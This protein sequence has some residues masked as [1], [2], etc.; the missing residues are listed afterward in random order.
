MPL[1]AAGCGH[2]RASDADREQA[3]EVLKVAFAQGR[4]AQD[5][6]EPRIGRAFAARTYAESGSGAGEKGSRPGSGPSAGEKGSRV[7]HIRDNFACPFCGRYRPGL[8]QHCGC[9]R[10][11]RFRLFL[12]LADRLVHNARE[13]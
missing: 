1:A 11:N 6:F 3:I 13:R 10:H 9:G 7:G 2:L 5:D 8:C 4:L 12:F